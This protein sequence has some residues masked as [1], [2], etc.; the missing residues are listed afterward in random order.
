MEQILPI[1]LLALVF[2]LLILRPMRNQKKEFAALQE[3]QSS[4]VP[5]TRIMMVSGIYG[6]VK[7]VHEDEIILEIA[8]AT[9]ITIAKG[10]VAN[11][12]ID[13]P[14]PEGGL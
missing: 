3:L 13:E 6:V 14:D 4:L 10:A 2:Y 12:V 8:P 5:G 9:D 7:S 11:V 1:L